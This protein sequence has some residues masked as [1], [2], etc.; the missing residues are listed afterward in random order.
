MS[1]SEGDRFIGKSLEDMKD[2]MNEMRAVDEVAEP[3][4]K[5]WHPVG[6]GTPLGAWLET[7][8]RPDEERNQNTCI[9]RIIAIGE[10]VEWCEK[11]MPGRTTVTHTT[12]APPTHWRWPEKKVQRPD[13]ILT[14]A[15]ALFKARNA[16]YGDNWNMVGNVLQGMFPNG[17]TLKTAHDHNRFHILSLMA[18]KMT[19]YTVN[20]NK[21]GHQDSIRDNTVYSAMQ[22]FIDALG[23]GEDGKT[24][25]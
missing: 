18:V 24:R 21:G 15:G 9:A 16:V 3:D 23:S 13:E 1:G 5:E 17:V 25:V 6:D 8:D 10:E 11:G 7:T 22:E 2:I 4:P 20:W 12:F 14:E 19:R